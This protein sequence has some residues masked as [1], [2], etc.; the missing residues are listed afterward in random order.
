MISTWKLQN[1][2]EKTER[3]PKNAKTCHVDILEQLIF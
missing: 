2:D 3:K 1:T